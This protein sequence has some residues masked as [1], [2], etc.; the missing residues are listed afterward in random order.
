MVNSMLGVEKEGILR[1]F[2]KEREKAEVKRKNAK[3][4][5]DKKRQS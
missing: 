1:K 4:D 2:S 3:E 5:K